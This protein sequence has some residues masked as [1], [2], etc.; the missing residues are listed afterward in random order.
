MR[1]PDAQLRAGHIPADLYRQLPDGTDARQVVIVQQAPRNYTGPVVLTM[2]AALGSGF[3][4]YLLMLLVQTT[5]DAA[6]DIAKAAAAVGG[7]GVGG[8]TLSLRKKGK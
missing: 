3:V 1:A 5:A 7:V 8:V 2:V 6:A 4:I